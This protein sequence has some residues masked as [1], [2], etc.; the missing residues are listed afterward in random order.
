[1]TFRCRIVR[2]VKDTQ[3]QRSC[4]KDQCLLTVWLCRVLHVG[5]G[6]FGSLPLR[7]PRRTLSAVCARHRHLR[8]QAY[9]PALA[10]GFSLTRCW[11][12]DGSKSPR[13]SPCG[14]ELRLPTNVTWTAVRYFLGSI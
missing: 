10:F 4:Q 12:T 11:L 5:N 9:S 1:M 13:L 8:P 7:L 14:T 6:D 3:G 2:I